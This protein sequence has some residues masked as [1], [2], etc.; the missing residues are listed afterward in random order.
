MK[1]K[2]SLIFAG[3]IVGTIQMHLSAQ[4]N[5][6]DAIT[7]ASFKISGGQACSTFAK[8]NWSFRRS[9]GKMTIKWGTSTSYDSSKS[10]Y[11]SNPINL[12]GLTPNTTYYYNVTG[13]YDNKNYQY[14]KSS[15]KTSGTKPTSVLVNGSK[16]ETVN[17]MIGNEHH[18]VAI[19]PDRMLQLSFYSLTGT[20]IVTENLKYSGA[21][22]NANS[23]TK[24]IAPG[25]YLLKIS[26]KIHA[27]V[28]QICIK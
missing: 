4:C 8:M 25:V 3:L 27:S 26:N 20:K 11:D 10:V 24:H 15:F 14:S 12:T 17:L 21:D 18:S 16:K 9:N 2:K 5:T 28:H 19:D 23:L 22:L 7:T 13:F 6:I 1:I